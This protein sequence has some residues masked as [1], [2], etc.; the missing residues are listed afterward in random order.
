[1]LNF[2]KTG[3]AKVF[4]IEKEFWKYHFSLDWEQKMNSVW[5]KKVKYPKIRSNIFYTFP[6]T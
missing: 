6:F 4:K 3:F 5:K 2:D 1:M